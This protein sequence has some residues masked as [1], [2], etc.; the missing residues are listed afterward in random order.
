MR[1]GAASSAAGNRNRK[2]RDSALPI[3][4]ASM[5]GLTLKIYFPIIESVSLP[6]FATVSY[7]RIS[8]Y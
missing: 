8:F 2:F 6:Q 3:R 7:E 4:C 1:A 5:T